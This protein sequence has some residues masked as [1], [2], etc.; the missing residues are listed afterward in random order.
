M[1]LAVKKFKIVKLILNKTIFNENI[2]ELILIKYWKLLPKNKILL[3]WIDINKLNFFY[4]SLNIN[5][6]DLLK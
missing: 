3:E 2:I 6:I 1:S 5:A 4:L